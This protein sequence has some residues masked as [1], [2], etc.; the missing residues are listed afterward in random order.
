M[1]IAL[2]KNT[3]SFI[4][5][6]AWHVAD[7]RSTSRILSCILFRVTAKD[8]M[9]KIA[10]T[11][12]KNSVQQHVKVNADGDG[13]FAVQAKS[14]YDVVRVLPENEVEIDR[15]SDDRILVRCGKFTS[16]IPVLSEEEFPTLPD[17]RKLDVKK[18][19]PMP[20]RQLE[21][22]IKH[23][24]FSISEDETRPYI[25]GALF[26][27]DKGILRMVTTDGHRMTV[28]KEEPEEAGR[29]PKNKILIPLPGI[30]EL[31]KFLE[32]GEE[33]INVSFEQGS[34]HFVKK[35]IAPDGSDVEILLSLR[36]TESE[37]PPY[38]AVIPRSNDKVCICNRSALLDAIRRV[39]VL[40]SER[41]RT[42]N[43]QL[44]QNT[45]NLRAEYHDAGETEEEVEVAYTGEQMSV[46]FNSAYLIHV[47]GALPSEQIEIRLGGELDG[48]IFKPAENDDFIGIV[49][50]IRL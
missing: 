33:K 19:F 24:S 39:S 13:A 22:L 7:K 35:V 3:L 49:M 26:E 28:Y 5:A 45:L 9:L 43:F 36:L 32:S 25:N 1:K 12:P 37:F 34:L 6:N 18:Q 31:E 48:A 21:R 27:S 8:G 16:R 20:S 46:G 10:A 29:I 41:Q 14:I 47:L 40:A 15:Y 38:E 17:P 4:L 30:R 50:P 23:T 42:I 2:N 11:N 44:V